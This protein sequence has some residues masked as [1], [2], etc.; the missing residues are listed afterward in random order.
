VGN[1]RTALYIRC[2]TDQQDPSMQTS[3]LQEYAQRRGLQIVGEFIDIASGSKDDRPQLNKVLALAKQRKI[4]T[5]IVWK[6]DRLGRSLHHLVNTIGELDAVGVAFVSLKDNLDFSTP[7]GRLMFGVI[8]AMAQFERDLIRERVRSG[9]ANAK[10]KGVVLGRKR[11]PVDI[12][13]VQR[14]RA[15]GMSF[16]AISRRMK[17]SVGTIFRATGR[18][19]AV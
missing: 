1:N 19:V 4:D 12:A 16:A 10:R 17:L 18:A 7:A 6:V 5:L 11:V 13:T 2:S 9:M 14:L 15:G 3:E 8:G